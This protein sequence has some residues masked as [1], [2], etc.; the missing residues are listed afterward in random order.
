MLS[1]VQHNHLP[2]CKLQVNLAKRAIGQAEQDST[3]PLWQV[4]FWAASLQCNSPLFNRVAGQVEVPPWP[5]NF[6]GSLPRSA[7]T[8]LEPILHLAGYF[9]PD[10]GTQRFLEPSKPCLVGSRRKALDEYSQMSAHV[11]GFPSFSAFVH[12]YFVLAKWATTSIRVN[13]SGV[14]WLGNWLYI[15]KYSFVVPSVRRW[16]KREREKKIHSPQ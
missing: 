13:T 6:R 15:S 11:P 1:S 16:T 14:S 8:V 10:I 5:V 3:L 7:S 2:R 9:R 12:H 4:V